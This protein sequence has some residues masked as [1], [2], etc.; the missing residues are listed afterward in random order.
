LER[1]KATVTTWLQGL[2]RGRT[3]EQLPSLERPAA[4]AA[5]AFIS[6]PGD[7]PPGSGA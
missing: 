3:A 1:T 6:I 2:Q 4:T 7:T 5:I